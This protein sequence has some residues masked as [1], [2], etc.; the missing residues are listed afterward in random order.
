MQYGLCELMLRM[1]KHGDIQNNSLYTPDKKLNILIYCGSYKLLSMVRFGP[2]VHG[3]I[4]KLLHDK[5]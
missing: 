1:F 3:I 4:G 2:P 5:G